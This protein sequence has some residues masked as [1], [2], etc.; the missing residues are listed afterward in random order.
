[1]MAMRLRLLLCLKLLDPEGYAQALQRLQGQAADRISEHIRYWQLLNTAGRTPEARREAE[2]YRATPRSALDVVQLIDGLQALGM[3]EQA[4]RT[5]RDFAPLYGQ[6][7]DPGGTRVWR[8]YAGLLAQAKAWDDLF[9]A[10]VQMRASP[11]N[12]RDLA[13][14]SYFLE[15]RALL[16]QGRMEEASA[17]F[18]RAAE[19]PFPTP[20][21]GFEAAELMLRS[22]HVALATKL[23]RRLEPSLKES[24]RYW[25]WVL[26][27]AVAERSDH[28]RFL[29]AAREAYR[30]E[31][32]NRIYQINYA[33]ALLAN[34]EA[35]AE[36]SKLT[37]LFMQQHPDLLIARLNHSFALAQNQRLQE[38]EELLKT[39]PAGA[40]DDLETT[41]YHLC[42][43]QVRFA[44]RQFA[45]CRDHLGLIKTNSLFPN[46]R[47][48][49]ETVRTQ[50][51]A[52]GVSTERR[53]AG[54]GD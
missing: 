33:A 21:A 38:A 26:E 22:G 11:R 14:L 40:L 8:L 43:V 52:G 4:L 51:E 37:L 5:L 16:G 46:Q 54:A 6:E 29:H 36:A 28:A 49:L 48:W 12:G 47:Q 42:W 50:V 32:T 13:G 2:A 15:G 23:L 25:Q 10:A 7:Q 18:A 35:P 39:I 41:M 9:A 17:A 34:R 1:M 3:Q 31:P 45:E 30:L 19:M 53:D 20:E 27:A 44:G 24:A